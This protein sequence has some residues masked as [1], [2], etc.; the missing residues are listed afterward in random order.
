MTW[1]GPKPNGVLIGGQKRRRSGPG[2][3]RHVKMEGEPGV[4]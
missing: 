1:A 4:M 3:G 2:R